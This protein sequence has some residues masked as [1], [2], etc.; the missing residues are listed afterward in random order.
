MKTAGTS[1]R[2]MLMEGLGA[3]AVYPNDADLERLPRGW[4][5]GP[6]DL[7][8]QVR[9]GAAGI[10]RMVIGHV[11]YTLV[12]EFDHRPRTIALV[13]DPIAR[14]VSMMDHRRTRSRR[15]R[16]ASYA[17]L[18][19]DERFVARQLRD[20]QTKMFAFDSVAECAANV[21]TP[22]AIDDERFERALARLEDV[23]VLGVVEDL[24]AFTRR[25]GAVTGIEA[26]PE[27]KANRATGEREPVTPEIRGR[28]ESL[29]A[30][31][32]ALY[33]RASQIVASQDRADRRLL[34]R[35]RSRMGR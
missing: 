34:T 35:L 11:P 33:G 21:N 4:Y 14:A 31:D 24:G 3:D 10:P 5:P 28:L 6:E 18:L 8:E 23:D 17:D 15:Y 7:V 19:D 2:G 29:T 9:S 25:L 26:G 27:R 12:D 13:R 22:L 30:R 20:Y 32:A 16:G 1:L